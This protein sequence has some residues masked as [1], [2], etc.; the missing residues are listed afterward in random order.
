MHVRYPKPLSRAGWLCVATLAAA[1]FCAPA[2]AVTVGPVPA[3]TTV[4]IG[5]VFE[6]R[7]VTDA[8]PDLKGFSLIYQ[9]NPAVLELIGASPGD[10][11]TSA[12]NPFTALLVPD[13]AAPADSA[14]YDAAMLVGVTHGPGI[15]N[16]FRFRALDI[17]ES[18]LICRRVDFRDSQNQQT[19]PAC[20]PGGVVVT[21]P[22]RSKATTW[23]KIKAFYR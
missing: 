12:G 19:L 18:P 8:F 15:L 6:I 22:T 2:G 4:N 3:D 17:G 10:V 9:Y 14:W 1:G 5:D 11:L 23:G 7:M 16:F 21:G 13:Y 20:N